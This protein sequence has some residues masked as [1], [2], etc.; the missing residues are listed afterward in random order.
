MAS[1]WGPL[2]SKVIRGN[3]RVYSGKV[4]KPEMRRL[5]DKNTG[6]DY[7]VPEDDYKDQLIIPLT[8]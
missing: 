4:N 7:E 6:K 1:F 5:T 2:P 8:R 3:S